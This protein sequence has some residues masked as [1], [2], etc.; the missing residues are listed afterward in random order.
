[1]TDV[2]EAVVDEMAKDSNNGDLEWRPDSCDEVATDDTAD[3]ED[4]IDNAACDVSDTAD[5]ATAIWAK[6]VASE[7]GEAGASGWV[8]NGFKSIDT[9]DS[10]WNGTSDQSTTDSRLDA[11]HRSHLFSASVV[12]N[13]GTKDRRE[14]VLN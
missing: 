5:E 10:Q 2:N 3:F 9:T 14:F 11:E 4:K 1:L 13:T 6:N 12:V 7:E 8:G